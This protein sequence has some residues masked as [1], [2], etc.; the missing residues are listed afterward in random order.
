MRL[1]LKPSA[2]V[3]VIKKGWCCADVLKLI[4][5]NIATAVIRAINIKIYFFKHSCRVLKVQK[6]KQNYLIYHTKHNTC[7]NIGNSIV[8]GI[9][10][11][12][13]SCCA[14]STT[15]AKTSLSG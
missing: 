8:A 15:C 4:N 2:S 7:T 12:G 1:S 14:T 3:L 6:N 9:K 11:N 13:F 10:P 5:T